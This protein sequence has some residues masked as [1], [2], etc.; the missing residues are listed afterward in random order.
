MSEPTAA[1]ADSPALSRNFVYSTIS[2]ASAGLLLLLNMVATRTLS[3]EDFG[4]L[5]WALIFAT[6]GE[7]L[8][9]LGV[10]QVTVRAIARDRSEAPRLLHNSLAL[11]ILPG[12][13]MFT[14]MAIV[15]FVLRPEP[16]VRVL[17]L[18]MLGSAI[19]RS[20]VLTVRGVLMGLERFG[21]ETLVVVLDRVLLLAA[22]AAALWAGYG[23]VG[24]GVVFLLAR[25]VT[26]SA[27]LGIA[28]QIVGSLTL[29]FDLALWRQLQRTAL[30]IG[31]FLIALNFY[32]YIDSVMLGVLSTDVEVALYGSAY[33]LYEGLSYVPAILSAVLTPRLSRLWSSDRHGYHR[34]MSQ[35]V[36]AAAGLAVVV[37]LPTWWLAR[38]LLSIAFNGSS[39]IDYGDAALAFRILVTG[40]G[41]IFVIWMLQ[42]VA[43]STFHER[44]LLV[45]TAVGAAV[46]AGLNFWL[47]P[48]YGRDGAAFAT[49]AG[50]CLTMCLL[51]YGL[52]RVLG[53]AAAGEDR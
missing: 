2:A 3:G 36:A 38:P 9:D 30:P 7:A 19:L 42:A 25:V 40:L 43:I 45:T 13:A 28:R 23:L 52:R 4:K 31:A 51:F 15:A 33:R 16:D 17:T 24:V 14:V 29:R 8:M 41:F 11:K 12:L 34:L 47:I 49:L 35:G 39:G 20:Y 27:A 46:N 26:V 50:E 1:P 6:I 44:L 53:R 32:S 21:A 22:S 37:A 5:T 48:A 18:F 10:H